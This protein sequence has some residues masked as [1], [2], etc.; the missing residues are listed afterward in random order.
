MIRRVVGAWVLAGVLALLPG[1]AGHAGMASPE[2]AMGGA[3]PRSLRCLALVALAEAGGEGE[4]GMAAVMQV[5]RNRTADG[6]FAADPC[7]VALEPGQFQPVMEQDWLRQALLQVQGG[8]PDKPARQSIPYGTTTLAAAEELARRTI[9]S[10]HTDPTEG[11][12]YF[13]NPSLID[14]AHCRWFATL[15]T[16]AVIGRHLFL[17]DRRP[18]TSGIDLDCDAV[19]PIRRIAGMALPGPPTPMILG[20]SLPRIVARRTLEGTLSRVH[21]ASEP[22]SRRGLI[23]LMPI[24]SGL[25]VFIR[26]TSP[27]Q[28]ADTASGQ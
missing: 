13:M 9:G 3:D 20:R 26:S 6:R 23:R 2:P 7:S 12:L 1:R 18:S 19:D 14:E 28:G 16:T 27:A 21:T 8:Q 10:S 11:A 15:A 22:M 5:M 17:T 25:V 4:R 24:S